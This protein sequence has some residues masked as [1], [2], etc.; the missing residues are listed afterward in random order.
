[1]QNVYPPIIQAHW[2]IPKVWIMLV[3]AHIYDIQNKICTSINILIL[4]SLE[5]Y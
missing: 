1:M 2:F 5:S 3:M 4:I